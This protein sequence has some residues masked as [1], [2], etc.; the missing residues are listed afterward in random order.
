MGSD[1]G[2]SVLSPKPQA[3]PLGRDGLPPVA[4]HVLEAIRS[5]G[6]RWLTVKEIAL[7]AGMRPDTLRNHLRPLL[8]RGLIE[9]KGQTRDRRYCA[10][11]GDNAGS[12]GW[13][14]LAVPASAAKASHAHRQR[15]MRARVLDHLSRRRLTEQSLVDHLGLDREGV[16]DVCGALLLEDR[17]VLLPDGSYEVVA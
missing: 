5:L 2:V 11:D 10:V 12:G 4:G 16:A 13:E 17:I 9:A 14:R 15:V 7:A 1:R 8:R 6:C 3:T